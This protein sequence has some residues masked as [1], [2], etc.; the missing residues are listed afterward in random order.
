VVKREQR[1]ILAGGV[2]LRRRGQCGESI[3]ELHENRPRTRRDL[4]SLR[5]VRPT[6]TVSVFDC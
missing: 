4:S 1:P 6:K 5:R 2:E 3:D